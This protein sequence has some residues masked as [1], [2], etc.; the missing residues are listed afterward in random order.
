MIRSWLLHA[1]T[2]VCSTQAWAVTH[3]LLLCSSISWSSLFHLLVL[4]KL[5]PLT[6]TDQLVSLS[7]TVPSPFH[8]PRL[9]LTALSYCVKLS[10][11]LINYLVPQSSCIFTLSIPFFVMAKFLNKTIMDDPYF[12][13]LSICLSPMPQG[14]R[15]WAE[16]GPL[17]ELVWLEIYNYNL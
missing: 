6:I 7:I 11:T 13:G 16:K 12:H 4:P 9:S 3:F 14:S 1:F 15:K 10:S 8:P 17:T 5:F 2:V